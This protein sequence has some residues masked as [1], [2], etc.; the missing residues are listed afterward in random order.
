MTDLINNFIDF[1]VELV[2]FVWPEISIEADVLAN[3]ETYMATGIDILKKVNFLVPVPLIFEIVGL[4][5]VF[6]SGAVVLWAIN[7]IIKRV[8]DVIP[9]RGG[10]LCMSIG[11]IIRTFIRAVINRF[12]SLLFRKFT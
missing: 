7:W 2:M 11:Y 12:V 1:I 4:M 5:V 8:F 9:Q 10:M 3:I 6:K